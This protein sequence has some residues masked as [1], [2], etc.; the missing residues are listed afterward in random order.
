[1]FGKLEKRLESNDYL[2]GGE[3]SIADLSAAMEL[4]QTILA[5]EIDL[6]AFTKM[7]AWK[8]RVLDL[9]ACTKA[10]EM[11]RAMASGKK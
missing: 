9:P 11:V 7:T 1:M 5:P 8:S 4:E 10:C 3:I 2:C 6:S